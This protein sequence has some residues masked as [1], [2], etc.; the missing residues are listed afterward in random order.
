VERAA[1]GVAQDLG[2]VARAPHREHRAVQHM[3]RRSR[4][5]FLGEQVARRR[6]GH[7]SA[8][9]DRKPERLHREVRALGKL[10]PARLAVDPEE[11]ARRLSLRHG[12]RPRSAQLRTVRERERVE[13]AAAGRRVRSV[14]RRDEMV[15]GGRRERKAR[16]V[17]VRDEPLEVAEGQLRERN[18]SE[19]G[20]KPRGR[21]R[22]ARAELRREVDVVPS[23]ARRIDPVPREQA[24]ASHAA[25]IA[26]IHGSATRVPSSLA[27]PASR[28][29]PPKIHV[30]TLV[31]RVAD[32][33][34]GESAA[35]TLAARIDPERFESTLC[36]TRPS[37]ADLL[38]E[39]AAAGVRVVELDRRG[40]LDVAAWATFARY[41]RDR[42]VDILHSHKFGSNVWAALAKR[43]L[44][45]SALVTHEH[46]WSFS[47]DRLR[48]LLDRRLIAPAAAAMIA[49]S[50]EDA[51]RMAELERI[52]R[53]KI[54]VIPN[55]IEFAPPA[56]PA[57]LRRELG[58]DDD[59]PVIGYVGGLRPEKRVD[60]L[61][62]AASALA[63]QGRE[64][65][66]ALVGSGPEEARLRQLAG[67]LGIDGSVAFLGFRRDATEL[68]AG[69]DVAV[70]PS[71]R[72]G[73]PLSLLEYMA[74]ARPIVATSVGGVPEL[75]E[76]EQQALL[77]APGN[78]DELHSAIAVLLDD[79]ARRRAL[80]LA[81]AARQ[82]AEF[83]L[84]TMTRRIEEL[85]VAVAARR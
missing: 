57:K 36:V 62:T 2:D 23:K 33:G 55:G 29:V 12:R 42:R 24:Q 39:I 16:L 11:E 1:V 20:P 17:S 47:G 60:L 81:A 27:H 58:W 84:S 8:V 56:D 73:A 53:A 21:P 25:E 30:L 9:L 38:A 74:L 64:L 66:V 65:H 82:S 63:G 40:R 22:I 52:P 10:L 14:L 6:L 78:H 41:V 15:G 76:H 68:A 26:S 75:V 71:D 34:G 80:G 69:F 49:V 48:M 7:D 4:R 72:E 32:A 5:V 59:R 85:Y 43:F 50:A 61:L 13:P 51:R 70:L 46:S 3:R 77:V 44:P 83:S 79:P 28:D 45:I 19:P 18:V 31:D 54:T 35:A 37:S 67:E